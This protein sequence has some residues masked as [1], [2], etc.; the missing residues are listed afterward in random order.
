MC[1]SELQ[2][3]LVDREEHRLY[4]QAPP[5]TAPASATTPLFGII[6][7]TPAEP[8]YLEGRKGSSSGK[9]N[10]GKNNGG[11]AK[12]SGDMGTSGS[13]SDRGQVAGKFGNPFLGEEDTNMAHDTGTD[14]NF[15]VI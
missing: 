13:S 5:S 4:D 10:F 9:G 12:N 2:S 1:T 7:F 8:L 14:S 3:L 11:K 15:R 6:G